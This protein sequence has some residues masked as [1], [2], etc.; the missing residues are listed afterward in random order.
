MTREQ[1][2]R[3]ETEISECRCEFDQDPD[4]PEPS[5]HYHRIC[6]H[7]GHEW[8]GL[9]CPH[10]GYQNPCPGCDIKPTPLGEALSDIYDVQN[11]P[12]LLKYEAEWMDAMRRSAKILGYS[13]EEQ[14]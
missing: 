2:L 14:T 7:C 13:N 5:W 9:H 1:R 10:D 3:R 4:D 12:P 11:G 8:W 6:L